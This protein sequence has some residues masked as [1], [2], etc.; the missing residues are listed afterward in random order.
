MSQARTR[1]SCLPMNS[2][3]EAMEVGLLLHFD[4]LQPTL[5]PIYRAGLASEVVNGGGRD[6]PDRVR[7]AELVAA[8]SL[9]ID[10]GFGQPME[11]VLR[12]C[13]IALRL[14]ECVGLGEEER[15]VVY[16]TALLVNVGCHSDAH[17][18]AKW[19][20]DDIA[21]KSGKYDHELGSMSGVLAMLRMI[22]SGN[23]PL[24]RFRVGLEFAVSGRHDLDGMI[25]QHA[26]LAR[27]LAED[28]G[29]SVGVQEAVGAA[30]EQWDGKGWPGDLAGDEIPIASRLAQ[31]GE[32]VEVAH[33]IGGTGAAIAL[34]EKRA[35]SQ[36]DPALAAALCDNAEMILEDLDAGHTWDAVIGAEPALG[37]LL[38]EAEFDR[39]LL[40]IADFVD[41]KSPYTLGHARAVSDAGRRGGDEAR[42]RERG[43]RDSA[44]GGPGQRPGASRRV[45]RHLGQAGATRGRGVGAGAHAPL[46]H[47]ADAPPVDRAGPAGRDR[48]AAPRAS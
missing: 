48:C 6:D 31:I 2:K 46:S 4:C 22:G 5:A 28:L 33:R 35:G 38:S 47:R 20:G 45:E 10:L 39:A 34:A 24:H 9:G 12:Q 25:A 8:L 30:Y 23:P 16:Y 15:S 17:E 37:V 14:A 3:R 44:P 29:L 7:L 27:R 1:N 19:F 26:A 18:Q 32:F 42:A 36:F 40:A 13:M 43:G 41:L 11:H 21:M